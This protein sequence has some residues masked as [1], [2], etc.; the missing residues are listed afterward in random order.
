[1]D[2]ALPKTKKAW[3]KF[4]RIIAAADQEFYE[5]G[6]EKTS[7]AN[8]AAAADIA[9]GTF[10]LYFTDKLSLYHYILFD[11][12]KRI[13]QYVNSK[14]D[15]C[16]NR[17]D[18]ERVGIIAWLEFINEN[19]HTYNIIWQSLAIDK[20]LFIDYYQKFSNSYEKG[21]KKDKDQMIDIDL[22]HLSLALMGVSTFL[23]LKPMLENGEK[24]T[25][26]EIEKIANSLTEVLSNG[27]FKK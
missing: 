12:Q 18:K 14:L 24:L 15:A 13:K 19:P 25:T 26:E 7:I 8:I 2:I 3:E 16:T 4:S 10:Y 22:H 5:K 21:L 17:K 20:S 6:Y 11:Y 23:G 9:V 1:M 27:L